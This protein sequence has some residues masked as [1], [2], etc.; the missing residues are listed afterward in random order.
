MSK[1]T[2]DVG[3]VKRHSRRC[4]HKKDSSAAC[5]CPGTW[6]AWIYRRVSGPVRTGYKIRHTLPTLEAA[7][8]WRAEWQRRLAGELG[9]EPGFCDLCHWPIV[10]YWD[11]RAVPTRRTK[12]DQCRMAEIRPDR[13]WSKLRILCELRVWSFTHGGLAPTTKD[14]AVGLPTPG[15]VTRYW[16]SWR[17]AL[18]AAGLEERRP[19]PAPRG[20]RSRPPRRPQ[21]RTPDRIAAERAYGQHLKLMQTVA[22]AEAAVEG[23]PKMRLRAVYQGL[24]E[25]EEPLRLAALGV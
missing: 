9:P 20:G 11:G 16:G 4:A 2:S 22:D 12:C 6:E 14:R 19:G 3:I 24:Y 5:D 18:K 17:K 10:A 8:A 23:M 21:A 13:E 7:R 15:T 25:V 1:P